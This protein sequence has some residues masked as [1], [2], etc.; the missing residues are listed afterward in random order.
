M[1]AP[2]HR[3][4]RHSRAWRPT[5]RARPGQR[6]A[7]PSWITVS[8]AAAGLVLL[9]AVVVV[10]VRSMSTDRPNRDWQRPRPSRPAQMCRYRC[11]RLQMWA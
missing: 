6:R 9:V 10:C 2:T 4:S 11:P 5:L 1:T 3:L 7:R 8:I